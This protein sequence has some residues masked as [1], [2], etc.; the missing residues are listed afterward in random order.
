MAS[1]GDDKNAAGVNSR[2][3]L[4]KHWEVEPLANGLIFQ[5]QARVYKKGVLEYRITRHGR[6]LMDWTGNKA[7]NSY[8]WIDDPGPG[9]MYWKCATV[10][11]GTR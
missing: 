8:I 10:N 1:L 11:S 3:G 2:K 4:P 7:N 5:V 9:I 6:P